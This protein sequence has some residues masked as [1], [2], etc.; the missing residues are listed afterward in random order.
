PTNFFTLGPGDRVEIEVLGDTTTRENTLV[1]PDG[2]IYFYLLPGL[3][4]WGLTLAQTKALLEHELQKYIRDQ[5]RV[6]LTLRDIQSKKVWLLGRLNAPGIYPMTGPMTL[7]EAISS[8]GGPVMSGPFASLAGR[9]GTSGTSASRQALADLHRSFVIRQGRLVPVDFHRLLRDG[10]LSQ[11]IY[12]EPDDFVYVPS[13]VSQSV[14]I[15]GAV[16]LPQAVTYTPQTTLIAAM[17]DVGG[18]LKDAYLSHVAIVR[19][20]LARPRVA[21]VD[22]KAIVRGRQPDVPLEPHDIVYVPFAPYRVLTRYVD[23]IMNTFVTTVGV[24]EGASAVVRGAS[25]VGTFLPVGR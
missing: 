2:R 23:T 6:S 16:N 13:T 22:Y 3:D 4:V 25:P 7:L 20:S 12:L 10:E 1:G 24:N 15:L 9:A 17:A 21:I 8:A 18:T 11:N 14:Y 19:G 5:P